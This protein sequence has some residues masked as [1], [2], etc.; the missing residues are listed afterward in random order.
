VGTHVEVAPVYFTRESFPEKEWRELCELHDHDPDSSGFLA[1]GL[2]SKF[3]V[4]ASRTPPYPLPA[5]IAA[6]VLADRPLEPLLD[7]L[8][9]D[10]PLADREAI[11]KRAYARKTKGGTVGTD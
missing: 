7:A 10:P 6:Y 9:R 3:P 2:T 8:H 5:L 1:H 11:K 4:G